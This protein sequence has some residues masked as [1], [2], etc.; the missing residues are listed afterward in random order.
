MWKFDAHVGGLHAHTVVG[1]RHV[2]EF[3]SKSRRTC[4][5]EFWTVNWLVDVLS[6]FRKEEKKMKSKCCNKHKKRA[7]NTQ[8]LP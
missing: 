4:T 6:V 5:D 2:D 8:A 1:K 7:K 3:K